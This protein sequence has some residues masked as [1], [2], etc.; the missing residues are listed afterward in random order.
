M[1]SVTSELAYIV[2]YFVCAGQ[3]PV[4][5]VVSRLFIL[6]GYRLQNLTDLQHET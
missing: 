2:L 6:E 5:Q 4:T 3:Q 1:P